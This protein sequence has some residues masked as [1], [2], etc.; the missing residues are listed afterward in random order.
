MGQKESEMEGTLL[1]FPLELID[2]RFLVYRKW[3]VKEQLLV[4]VL[5][6][7]GA[8]MLADRVVLKPRKLVRVR[9]ALED[10]VQL[11]DDR[12]LMQICLYLRI[13]LLL[14]ERFLRE[15]QLLVLGPL[16][17]VERPMV[18]G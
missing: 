7:K 11:E 6:W 3:P 9:G 14:A 10:D 13:L 15:E 2:T 12:V 1:Q 4:H 5:L 18:Y 8:D 16:L 17:L